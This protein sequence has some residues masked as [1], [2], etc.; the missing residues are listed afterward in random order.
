M[1]YAEQAARTEVESPTLNTDTTEIQIPRA[2]I[3]AFQWGGIGALAKTFEE[4]AWS[5][6]QLDELMFSIFSR[7]RRKR[8]SLR[9]E[10]LRAVL[11]HVL[12]NLQSERRAFG[13]A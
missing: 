8:E 9:W 10:M 2:A 7:P 5:T 6:Q 11:P 4:G 1:A 3:Q 12:F 13:I